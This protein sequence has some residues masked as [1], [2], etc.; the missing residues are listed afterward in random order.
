MADNIYNN[1]RQRIRGLLALLAAC[2]IL[3]TAAAQQPP[4]SP[5][6]YTEADP[7]VYED[8]WDLW[9]YAFLNENGVP[10]GYNI[11]LLK[12][13]FKRLGIPYV[14]K[15]RATQDAL[16]DLE[17]GRSDLMLGMD[18]KF[19]H[20]Y[21][22]YGKTVVQLFTHSVAHHKNHTPSVKSTDDLAKNKVIVH[23]GS[24][25]HHLM[26]DNGWGANAEPYED[27]QEAVNIAHSTPGSEILWN[28]LSLKWLIHKY[29]FENMTLSPVEMQH[30]EYKFMSNDQNLLHLLD[31]AYTVLR[32]ENA[33]QPIQ[34][35]WFYPERRD[36]GIPRWVWEVALAFVAVAVFFLIY[37]AVYRIRE[38]RM[39]QA[40]RKSNNRLAIILKTSKVHIWSINIPTHKITRLDNRGKMEVMALAP[41][42]A[43]HVTHDSFD[44]L[45]ATLR[46]MAAK[47]YDT[48]TIDM[49]ALQPG[50]TATRQ[51]SVKLSVLRRNRNERPTDIIGVAS[52]VTDERRRQQQVKDNMLRYQ[53]IFNSAM[54]DIVAYDADGVLSDINTKAAAAL[55]ADK[56]TIV[57]QGI[58][59]QQ[60][61]GTDDLKLDD[62]D[63]PLYLT[64]IYSSKDDKRILNRLL[65]RDRLY[66]ELQVVPIRNDQG[67]MLG[68]L[69]TGRNVTDI[70]MSYQQLK[71]NSQEMEKANEEMQH[72]IQ[73][74]DYVLQNGGVRMVTYSPQ[75][76]TL[77]IFR[78][79][80]R[81]Q[82]TLTQTRVLSL[83]DEESKRAVQRAINSMDNYTTSSIT[84]TLKT[85]LRI[86]GGKR[87][88][89]HMSFVPTYGPDGRV[90]GYFGMGRDVSDIKTTE[91]QLACE[92]RKAQEV[93]TVKN[94]F[95]HNMSYEIR[96]PLNTVVGFA[97]LFEQEHSADD[98]AVFIN[99]IKQSSSALLKLINDILF[100]SRLDARMIEFKQKPCEFASFF[101]ARC[102]SAWFNYQQPGVAFDVD[103]PYTRLVA[104]IDEQNVGIVI[105]QLMTRAALS[106]TAGSV[107]AR[108][109]YTGDHLVMAFQDSSKG[110]PEEELPHFFERFTDKGQQGTG[111]GMSIC[112]ELVQQ[113]GGAIHIKSGL[114]KG[115]IIWVTIPCKVSEIERK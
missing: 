20:R 66:Y 47:K 113:M 23:A 98:E 16:E 96:T 69:G 11:D 4:E 97:E 88:F 43:K 37:Y 2:C 15:L 89:M 14:I 39:T 53:E 27:M 55:P 30:G 40:V 108:Y 51:L 81:P 76:H 17:A 68:I 22:A 35:K 49:E 33:L 105:D 58:T 44:K 57:A 84:V 42:F 100:L 12:M 52:D 101:E 102:R 36:T 107:R 91:E 13:M 85:T 77:T 90:N 64:Q 111:L 7:L 61:L 73:D 87:L 10:V 1:P 67:K 104:D 24:F 71:K 103:N 50:S 94:A 86:K 74:V 109:D 41:D 31:S 54:A 65:Q 34:N 70:A 8:A 63:A 75:T 114:G 78:E 115:V 26:Q 19:H 99:E 62:L 46:E 21:A 79:I 25:S 5:R 3:T 110:I 59:I 95:L 82:Y 28:T 60:V 32:S 93:E 9:P 6:V 56:D 106:T 92:T 112:Q 45:N 83:I 72:Y 18:A 38:K 80:N 29:N 48:C